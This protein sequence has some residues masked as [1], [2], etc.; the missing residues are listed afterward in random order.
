MSEWPI[1][2]TIDRKGPEL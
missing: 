1:G 2:T